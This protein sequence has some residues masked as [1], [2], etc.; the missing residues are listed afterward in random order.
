MSCRNCM[1]G[2]P[3]HIAPLYEFPLPQEL[4]DPNSSRLTA[5]DFKQQ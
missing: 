5:D 1:G 2:K 3:A 4:P